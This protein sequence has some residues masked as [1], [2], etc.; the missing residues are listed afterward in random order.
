V[1]SPTFQR[2]TNKDIAAAYAAGAPP[3]AR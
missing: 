1:M 3:D 2:D